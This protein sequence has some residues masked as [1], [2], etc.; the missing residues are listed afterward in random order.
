MGFSAE[1]F[2]R[3]EAMVKERLIAAGANIALFDEIETMSW[4]AG[5]G[6][7]ENRW[8][9]VGIP[10]EG[11][12]FFL[13]RHLDAGPCAERTWIKEVIPFKD[14]ENPMLP[15]ADAFC[16]RGLES[17]R[18]GLDFNSYGMPL[19]RFEAIKAALPNATFVDLGPV[20]WELRLKKSQE[21]I[22]LIQKSA[23]ICDTA[24]RRAA[25]LC[26]PGKRLRAVQ[27]EAVAT[28]SEMDGDV[29]S[30]ILVS[31][32][33][34]STFLH[35][36]MSEQSLVEGDVVHI[37]VAPRYQGYS[38]REMRCVTVGKVSDE[39]V[40]NA[41]VLRDLQD[42]QI[43]AMRPG[44]VAS[45]IDRIIREGVTTVGLR[46]VYDNITGYTLGFYVM[47]GPRTSDFTRIFH[48][49]ADWKLEVGQVFHMY[50]SAGGVAFS[51]AVLVSVNGA[52]RL[53]KLPRELFRGG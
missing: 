18:I 1:E 43:E 29:T 23:E 53:T 39:I 14:W 12:P 44:A 47:Q 3:R 37:E 5:Y 10:L 17:A 42:K 38:S 27:L 7:S 35:A 30:P 25:K 4:V 51:E 11:E 33:H 15:L 26:V 49:K 6:N 22:A 41:V 50:A 20:I 8:R 13:I 9:C 28:V 40:R 45:D 21:E 34:G 32:A 24:I 46:D 48:P 19:A 36:H 31:H 2:H 16:K 52:E